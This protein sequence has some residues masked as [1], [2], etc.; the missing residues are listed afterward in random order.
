LIGSSARSSAENTILAGQEQG[1]AAVNEPSLAAPLTRHAR[2]LT[3]FRRPLTMIR[4]PAHSIARVSNS[5]RHDELRC[6]SHRLCIRCCW[7]VSRR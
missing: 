4:R 2:R 5:L 7:L 6:T 1:Y 3:T